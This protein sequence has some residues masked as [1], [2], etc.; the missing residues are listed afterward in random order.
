MNVLLNFNGILRFDTFFTLVLPPTYHNKID[1]F[2]I[3]SKTVTYKRSERS[4]I[5]LDKYS[6]REIIRWK[7]RTCLQS[8]RRDA[9]IGVSTA[10]NDTIGHTKGPIR[11]SSSRPSVEQKSEKEKM[12]KVPINNDIAK[13]IMCF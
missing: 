7:R 13:K 12:E 1:R 3:L 11:G 2:C 4:A 9:W 5:S 8:M 10:T 6:Q